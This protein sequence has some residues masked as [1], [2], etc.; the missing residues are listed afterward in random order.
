MLDYQNKAS[1]K[2]GV[3]N[4][5]NTSHVFPIKH[6]FRAKRNEVTVILSL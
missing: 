2:D 4:T 1:E 5:L 6:R 3:R